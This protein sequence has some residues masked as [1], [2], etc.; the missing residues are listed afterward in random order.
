MCFP[1]SRD[2][3]DHRYF[4]PEYA[5]INS[6]Q[7]QHLTTAVDIYAFGVLALVMA[8]AIQWPTAAGDSASLGSQQRSLDEGFF[9]N[10]N[11]QVQQQQQ[12]QSNE[13]SESKLEASLGNDLQAAIDKLGNRI[14]L[15]FFKK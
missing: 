5:L 6:E 12:Q 7:R 8:S 1:F 13:P 3:I 9:E 11:Q 2:Q 15:F 14:F 10:H 4:A